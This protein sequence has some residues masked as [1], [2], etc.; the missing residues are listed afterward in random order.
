MT[1]DY[2]S[3]RRELGIR[4]PDEGKRD[5]WRRRDTMHVMYLRSLCYTVQEVS[6]ILVCSSNRVQW[7]I[8]NYIKISL[9]NGYFEA[10]CVLHDREGNQVA[11]MVEGGLKFLPHA[12]SLS[13]Y[14]RELIEAVAD[15]ADWMR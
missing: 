10:G 4:I 8:K 14:S 12:A 9:A 11:C 15:Y 13:V 6:D 3:V 1:D 2:E 5:R 7:S